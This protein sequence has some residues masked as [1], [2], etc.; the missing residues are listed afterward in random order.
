M[1]KW[2]K[3]LLEIN[4]IHACDWDNMALYEVGDQ[5]TLV[6]IDRKVTKII[7]FD[8]NQ[9]DSE[10]VIENYIGEIKE[11]SLGWDILK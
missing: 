4:D 3:D 7:V 5:T 11:S 2:I 9:I 1:K 6:L 8:K 10:L